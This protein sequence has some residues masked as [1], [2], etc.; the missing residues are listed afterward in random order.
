MQFFYRHVTDKQIFFVSPSL[1]KAIDI[2]VWKTLGKKIIQKIVELM[3]SCMPDESSSEYITAQQQ[4]V[5][6]NT[7]LQEMVRLI[8]L[9]YSTR[10]TDIFTR[11]LEKTTF[12]LLCS[13]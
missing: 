11:D 6:Q 1:H 13:M 8:L 7:G 2:D 9:N 5:K 3:S 10:K 12:S 4:P